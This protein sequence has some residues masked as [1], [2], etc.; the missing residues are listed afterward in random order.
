MA[1]EYM[2]RTRRP[3]DCAQRAVTALILCCAL[4][5]SAGVESASSDIPVDHCITFGGEKR[6]RPAPLSPEDNQQE[7]TIPTRALEIK[8]TLSLPEQ[9]LGSERDCEAALTIS[10]MQMNDTVS[11][12]TT[13]A[14][15]V[16]EASHGGYVLDLRTI[17]AV[18]EVVTRSFEEVWA[19]VDDKPVQQTH[20]YSMAGAT[21]LLWVR[22]KPI[23][24]E[25]C[26]CDSHRDD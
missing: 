17:D 2:F 24:G 23:P 14:N 16:C 20:R 19:R 22:V 4:G 5:H 26:V 7:V 25:A 8:R 21:D 10:Y 11:I 13:V 9:Q 12:D 6:C 1:G 15:D 3:A 18:G